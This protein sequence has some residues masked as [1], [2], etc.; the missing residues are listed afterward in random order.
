MKTKVENTN[1]R[2]K[3][4][5]KINDQIEKGDPELIPARKGLC[6]CPKYDSSHTSPLVG[7]KDKL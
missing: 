7:I 5:I 4:D 2:E 1:P 3:E 6:T